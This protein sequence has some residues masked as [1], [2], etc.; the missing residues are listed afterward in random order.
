MQQVISP[1]SHKGVR[2]ME[3]VGVPSY[4]THVRG[5][6][7][8]PQHVSPGQKSLSGTDWDARSFSVRQA[9]ADLEQRDQG[10]SHLRAA[11]DFGHV[12][13]GRGPVS[14]GGSFFLFTRFPVPVPG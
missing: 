14:P 10:R 6:F 7:T 11:C 8:P 9:A 4:S 12:Q 3:V 2:S 1:S 5:R 13:V